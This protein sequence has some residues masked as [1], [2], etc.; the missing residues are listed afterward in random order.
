MNET[1]TQPENETHQSPYP[2]TTMHISFLRNLAEQ[3]MRT[4]QSIHN[5]QGD[6][7]PYQINSSM[8]IR[9]NESADLIRDAYCRVESRTVCIAGNGKIPTEAV[10][11]V[12][13]TAWIQAEGLLGP[14]RDLRGLGGV[15]GDAQNPLQLTLVELFVDTEDPDIIEQVKET[16]MID[17]EDW[18]R[19]S[20]PC[21]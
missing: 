5:E 7:E 14:M 20:N 18:W 9:L 11:D 15:V 12:K 8:A 4:A 6:C 19:A 1:Q 2:N 13:A 3:Y 17:I 10:E 21:T 16:I